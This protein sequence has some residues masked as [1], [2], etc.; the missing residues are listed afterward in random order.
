MLNSSEDVLEMRAV[1]QLCRPFRQ[2]CVLSCP[3][4]S[5]RVLAASDSPIRDSRAWGG[6][7]G[8]TPKALPVKTRVQTLEKWTALGGSSSDRW[9]HN[10]KLLMALWW[11]LVQMLSLSHRTLPAPAVISWGRKG[12]M[13]LTVHQSERSLTDKKNLNSYEREFCDPLYVS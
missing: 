1:W 13:S 8:N 10:L 9:W 6:G 3:T 5:S 2:C 12:H 11:Q 4:C 7:A